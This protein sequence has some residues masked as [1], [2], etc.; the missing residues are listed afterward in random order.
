MS[1][2]HD[3]R[4]AH[5]VQKLDDLAHHAP[6]AVSRHVDRLVCAAVAQEVRRE[7]A[8]AAAVEEAELP[9]PVVGARG[10]AVEEEQ[11][12]LAVARDVVHVAV[13]VA[14]GDTCRVDVVDVLDALEIRLVPWSVVARGEGA[15]GPHYVGTVVDGTFVPLDTSLENSAQRNAHVGPADGEA[16]PCF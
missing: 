6:E 5:A 8:V 7:D 12:G 14:A 11:R 2:A 1:H 10:E 15:E 16:T 4:D 3:R 13:G 9:A